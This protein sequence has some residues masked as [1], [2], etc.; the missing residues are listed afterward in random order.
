MAL[1]TE[2]KTKIANFLVEDIGPKEV[3]DGITY[4]LLSNSERDMAKA[5]ELATIQKEVEAA[6]VNVNNVLRSYTVSNGVIFDL[7]LGVAKQTSEF[8]TQSM[9]KV[10]AIDK[11]KLSS[12]DLIKDGPDKR[13]YE[14]IVKL[15]KFLKSCYD[16]KMYVVDIALFSRNKVGTT[17]FNAKKDGKDVTVKYNA[18]AIRHWDIGSL[19]DNILCKQ[20]FA[21][22]KIEAGEI[23]PSKNGVRFRLT[24]SKFGR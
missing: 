18:Y 24:L 4:V 9:C 3:L 22:S 20:G 13:R 21:V 14:D 12:P 6:G 11:S 19:N 17:T 23:L 8:I 16:K 1:S 5:R 7:N 15:G 2:T 10:G